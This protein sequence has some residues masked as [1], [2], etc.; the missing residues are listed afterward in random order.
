MIW[1][2]FSCLN[3]KQFS[4]PLRIRFALLHCQ[5]LQNKHHGWFLDVNTPI[6]QLMCFHE[7]RP[8]FIM[9]TSLINISFF[10]LWSHL[11]LIKSAKNEE[12][13]ANCLADSNSWIIRTALTSKLDLAV[14]TFRDTQFKTIGR[15]PDFDISTHIM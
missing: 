8:C 3:L 13:V 12:C 9:I 11:N 7:I 5:N 15:K 4:D 2:D 6:R 10:W 14:W 1:S